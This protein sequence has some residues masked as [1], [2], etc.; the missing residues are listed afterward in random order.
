M[1]RFE[2]WYFKHQADGH[3]LAVIAG[4]ADAH[5]FVQI[6]TES[7]SH[8]ID[9]PLSEYR[10]EPGVLSVGRNH[11]TPGGLLLDAQG[12]GV[13]I[14]GEIAYEGLTPLPSDIMGP[15]RFLPMQC[16]HSV[17]SMSHRLRGGVTLNGQRLDFAGGTGYIE[18]DNGSS[19]PRRYTWVQCGDFEEPLSVMASVAEIPF[20]GLTFQGCICAIWRRGRHY[21]LATYLGA[22]VLRNDRGALCLRQGRYTLD[23][24]ADAGEGQALKAPLRGA[25]TG[26]IR[27]SAACRAVFTFRDG[28]RIIFSAESGGASYEYV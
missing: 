2:G 25:M 13:Y 20:A 14:A 1:K 5:A 18:G 7:G 16:R 8:C 4:R 10:R 26:M 23:I 21:R 11:F 22:R 24:R 9:Y 12:D 15:F 3:T 6:L 19:F 28:G 27:E 17:G